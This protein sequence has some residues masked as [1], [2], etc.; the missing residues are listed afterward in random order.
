MHLATTPGEAALDGLADQ[1][2]DIGPPVTAE[3]LVATYLA[4]VHRFAVM[5]SPH[6]A[7]ADDLAQQ[8]MVRALER[9]GRFDPGRGSLDA[10]LWR[11]VVN[12]ARDAGRLSRRSEL[13]RGRLAMRRDEG[14]TVTSPETIAL[15][16][17]R[18]Q[19]LVDAVRRLPRRH[20]SL[21]A[22]RY[23]AGLSAA[24]IAES[25]GTTRMTVAKTLRRALDRLRADLEELE[26]TV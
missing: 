6:G 9:L 15:D 14:T 1:P 8:A 21:V 25:L 2:R 13:L 16:H 11:V 22:L 20:R 19:Q 17:L 7:D 10:W 23:G 4:R 12:L 18:D 24:E 3:E 26:V 5:V